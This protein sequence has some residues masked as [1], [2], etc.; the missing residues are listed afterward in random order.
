AAA[1]LKAASDAIARA[2]D[3]LEAAQADQRVDE[4]RRLVEADVHA[5]RVEAARRRERIADG[6]RRVIAFEGPLNLGKIARITFAPHR[7]T[8]V[9]QPVYDLRALAEGGST[10]RRSAAG[11][12]GPWL[13]Y[14]E[15]P[16]RARIEDAEAL[17]GELAEPSDD[18]H[19]TLL[20]LD[21][22]L[23]VLEGRFATVPEGELTAVQSLVERLR[24]AAGAA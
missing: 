11:G 12:E 7:N 9:G 24:A 6:I 4:L 1:N 22:L 16:S 21:A 20:A 19:R 8:V 5:N 14:L 18:G 3:G 2:L 15:S 10:S 17:R 23:G 13:R